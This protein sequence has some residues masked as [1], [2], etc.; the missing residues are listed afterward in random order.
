MKTLAQIEPRAPISAL[1]FTIQGPGAYYLTTNLTG[2]AGSAGIIIDADDV[3]L[4]L[5]GFALFGVTNSLAGI[6]VSNPH[7]NL[8]IRNGT[9][10]RWSAGIDAG[11]ASNS[12][13]E[14]LRVYQNLGNGLA[15]GS[16][17]TIDSCRCYANQGIGL[18]AGPSSQLN[19]CTVFGNQLDG[20]A[21]D[22]ETHLLSCTSSSN[23][24]GGIKAGNN[25]VLNG[26]VSLNN[27]GSG[28]ATGTDVQIL[29]TKSSNNGLLG[30]SATRDA[31]IS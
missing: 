2:T 5:N 15:G 18:S 30:I 11:A 22:N 28:I 16:G 7:G 21:V 20:I 17:S 3:T 27:A 10:S 23:Q 13:F 31:T 4:D 19:R 6:R 26:C 14:S 8:V 25:C 12:R 9:I 29:S 24:A 1:P